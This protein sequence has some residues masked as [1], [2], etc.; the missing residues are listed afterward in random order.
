[1]FVFK[2]HGLGAAVAEERRVV[3][4]ELIQSTLKS[5]KGPDVGQGTSA[6]ASDSAKKGKKGG[7][8]G[9]PGD[10]LTR[11]EKIEIKRRAIVENV[12]SVKYIL[13]SS[14]SSS[15]SSSYSLSKFVQ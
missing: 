5:L 8:G 7:V 14:S 11:A 2:G 15:S 9:E 10:R 3:L 12:R 13:S 4:N 1:M 6:A